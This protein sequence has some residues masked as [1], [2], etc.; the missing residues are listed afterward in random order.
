MA[1]TWH[2]SVTGKTN[3]NK[4]GEKGALWY[5]S[6]H[7]LIQENMKLQLTVSSGVYKL[8]DLSFDPREHSS[9]F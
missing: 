3:L 7:S 8:I 4:C 1:K 6:L 9:E 5:F 2:Q